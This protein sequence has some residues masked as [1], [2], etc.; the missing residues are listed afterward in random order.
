MGALWSVSEYVSLDVRSLPAI[1]C[2]SSCEVSE[3]VVSY[4]KAVRS[5]VSHGYLQDF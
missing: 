3:V 1:L 5:L 2:V 4:V